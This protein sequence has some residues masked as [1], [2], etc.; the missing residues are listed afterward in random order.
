[1]SRLNGCCNNDFIK[2]LLIYLQEQVRRW[3]VHE[4]ALDAKEKNKR[5]KMKKPG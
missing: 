4:K 5:A 2:V 3:K 1:M